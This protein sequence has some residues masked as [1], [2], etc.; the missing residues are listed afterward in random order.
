MD[1]LQLLWFLLIFLMFL[2]GISF[3]SAQDISSLEEVSSVEV[4]DDVISVDD[5]VDDV[6]TSD[7][8]DEVISDSGSTQYANSWADLKSDVEDSS[9][10]T[11]KLNA[12]DIAPS[13]SSSDQISINHDITIVGEEG[14]Y[15]G[16][17]DWNSAPV[18]N[19]IPIVTSGNNLNVNFENVTF[20]YLSDN[21]L[22]KLMGNGNYVFKNCALEVF[23]LLC[24]F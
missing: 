24:F 4:A 7:V 16:S 17:A 19:Y 12:S 15:I 5:S 1:W 9:V 8:G 13:S 10:D 21:I 3:V 2:V 11:V 20:Q 22:M 14:S 6:S 23:Q 18:Y